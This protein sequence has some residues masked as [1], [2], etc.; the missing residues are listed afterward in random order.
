MWQMI[1]YVAAISVAF[2]I[3]RSLTRINEKMVESDRYVAV[4]A[5]RNEND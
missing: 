4:R 5:K 2:G 3:W 1:L